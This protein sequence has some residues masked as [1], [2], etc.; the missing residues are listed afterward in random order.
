MSK[1]WS[2]SLIV[3]LAL[4]GLHFVA[5]VYYMSTYA[6]HLALVVILP[7][8]VLWGLLFRLAH[9]ED[10]IKSH[11]FICFGILVLIYQLGWVIRYSMLWNET[12]AVCGL[13]SCS[14]T[15]TPL[16]PAP[17]IPYHPLG[18]YRASNR[19]LT[20]PYPKDCRWG[21]YIANHEPLG[22]PAVTGTDPALPDMTQPSCN[23]LTASPT[24]TP[25]PCAFLATKRPQ[26]YLDWAYGLRQGYFLGVTTTDL[27]RCPYVDFGAVQ[28][29]GTTHGVGMP[30]CA[31]CS[32][33]LERVYNLTKPAA[34]CPDFDGGWD[35]HCYIC[36]DLSIYQ[37]ARQRAANIPILVILFAVSVVFYCAE[38]ANHP[39]V[40]EL[41]GHPVE[42]D[43]DKDV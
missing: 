16:D 1:R 29:D 33:Y 7:S 19:Y 13:S 40:E 24:P 32:D 11:V 30:I 6:S 3:Y 10:C 9:F 27:A 21:D 20:C 34:G 37:S 42:L 26:D 35:G 36:A 23:S 12:S 31:H 17:I 43:D 28:A 22:Y 5:F 15:S 8:G 38:G 14:S 2:I 39:E 18:R 41:V 25:T 4:V